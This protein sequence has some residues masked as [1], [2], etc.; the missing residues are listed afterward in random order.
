MPRIGPSEHHHAA[1]CKLDAAGL[2]DL[3][4]LI[5]MHVHDIAAHL[6]RVAQIVREVWSGRTDRY[7]EQRAADDRTPRSKVE[8]YHIG[9]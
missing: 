3:L 7:S 5:G 1:V 8:M 6:P 9:G 4:R 2:L